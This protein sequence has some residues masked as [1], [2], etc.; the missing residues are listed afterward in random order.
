MDVL[1][2]KSLDKWIMLSP[3]NPLFLFVLVLDVKIIIG[4]LGQ[5]YGIHR[6]LQQLAN[7]LSS[8]LPS[9]LDIYAGNGTYVPPSYS[10]NIANSTPASLD[11]MLLP[12]VFSVRVS[13]GVDCLALALCSFFRF[14][15]K[16]LHF[17]LI[18]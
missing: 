15:T 18:G 12:A 4:S 13:V 8:H 17:E 10:V 5:T 9:S 16:L 14:S 7:S 3:H 1:A 11:S 2:P 6:N